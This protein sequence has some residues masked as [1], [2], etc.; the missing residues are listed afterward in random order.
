MPQCHSAQPA[1]RA[2]TAP[3][4]EATIMLLLL[5]DELGEAVEED[6]GEDGD[7]EAD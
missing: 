1:S 3:A 6:P 7:E 5:D 4:I 2:P